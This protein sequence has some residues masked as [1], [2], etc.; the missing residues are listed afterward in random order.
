MMAS[1]LGASFEAFVLDDE[2][3]GHVHRT[4]RGIEVD[5]ERLGFEAIREAVLGP[6]HF[7]GS[8]HTMG[9]MQRDYLYPALADRDPPVTWAEKGAPDIWARAREKARHILATHHP[10]YLDRGADAAIRARFRIRL[11]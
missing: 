7:L 8:A 5:E 10:A 6:G 9:S 4:I 1:L 2:M 3:L 11:P